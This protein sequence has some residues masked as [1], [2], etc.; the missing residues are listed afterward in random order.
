MTE[1]SL[2]V[3]AYEVA[4]KSHSSMLSKRCGKCRLGSNMRGWCR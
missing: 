1:R 2:L 4:T 3:I